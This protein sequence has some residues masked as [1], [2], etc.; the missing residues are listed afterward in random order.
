[1]TTSRES[2]DLDRKSIRKVTGSTADFGELAQDCVCFANGTAARSSSASRTTP[3]HRPRTSASSQRSSI[4]SV[5]A[6]A[7]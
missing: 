1:M 7:S 6:S 5:T 4:E 2:H 3:T